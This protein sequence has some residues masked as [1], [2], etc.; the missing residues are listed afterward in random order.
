MK[1]IGGMESTIVNLLQLHAAEDSWINILANI[2]R[3]L[4]INVDNINPLSFCPTW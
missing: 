2:T 1:C 4:M 3:F